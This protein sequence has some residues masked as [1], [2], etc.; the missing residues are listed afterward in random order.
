MVLVINHVTTKYT[1][2][3]VNKIMTDFIYIFLIVMTVNKS[4]LNF[5]FRNSVVTI[6][7][8]LVMTYTTLKNQPTSIYVKL[9]QIYLPIYCCYDYPGGTQIWFG[10]GSAA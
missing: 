3:Q 7:L 10:R 9:C 5:P 1:L 4:M 8:N 2:Q 6:T